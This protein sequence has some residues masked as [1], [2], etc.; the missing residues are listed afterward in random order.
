MRGQVIDPEALGRYAGGDMNANDLALILALGLPLAWHLGTKSGKGLLANILKIINLCY[1]PASLIAILLTASRTAII[2]VIPAI[3]YLIFT[4]QKLNL[5]YRLAFIVAI[6]GT[7]I[8][9]N[10]MVPQSTIERLATISSSIAG[11]DLGGRMRLWRESLELFLKHPI[12][13]VGA[14]GLESGAVL[15]AVAHNTFISILAETGIVGFLF[16]IISLAIIFYET[17]RMPKEYASLWLCVLA[18]WFI[19]VLTLSWEFR[20]PTWLFLSW[21]IISARVY[22]QEEDH[23]Q[24]VNDRAG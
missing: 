5:F 1:I 6:L 4:I 22:Q 7:L 20:K 19:G 8:V 23:D 15:G 2:V 9:L 16:Y 24:G 21:V 13:G 18:V 14:G 10:G 11:G 12:I 3:L 17:I